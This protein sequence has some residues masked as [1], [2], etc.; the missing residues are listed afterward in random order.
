[1]NP[2]SKLSFL[3]RFETSRQRIKP[4]NGLPIEDLRIS[5]IEKDWEKWRVTVL[6]NARLK[7]YK[8]LLTRV[9]VGPSNENKGYG[10]F[11]SSNNFS[12]AEILI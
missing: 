2:N 11:V 4:K 9:E 3:S 12:Y 7:G 6:A 10:A 1:L 8:N 5:R